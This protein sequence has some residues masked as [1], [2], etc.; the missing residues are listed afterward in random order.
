MITVQNLRKSQQ[1]CSLSIQLL[2]K[3]L[4][5]VKWRF[6]GVAFDYY[7]KTWGNHTSLGWLRFS[8]KINRHA[9][10]NRRAAGRAIIIRPFGHLLGLAEKNWSFNFACGSDMFLVTSIWSTMRKESIN[11]WGCSM[12]TWSQIMLW[13]NPGE[14][15]LRATSVPED[16]FLS[17]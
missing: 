15:S 13:M 9:V 1:C 7:A 3:Q 17:V 2:E 12:R 11:S 4:V 5:G 16:K 8:L 10:D 6:C 14:E